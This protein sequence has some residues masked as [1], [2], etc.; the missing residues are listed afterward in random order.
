MYHGTCFNRS[1]N[2]TSKKSLVQEADL[3][4]SAKRQR[5]YLGEELTSLLDEIDDVEED[6]DRWKRRLR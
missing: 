2:L 4:A 5:V 6:R 3:L 1:V